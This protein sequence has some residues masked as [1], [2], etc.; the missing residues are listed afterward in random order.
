MTHT[1]HVSFPTKRPVDILTRTISTVLFSESE[2]IIHNKALI[3]NDKT[4][5]LNERN[6]L[7][8]VLYK[9]CY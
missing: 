1:F 7:F 4:A 9:D 3:D 2:L 5:D 8:R 6:F